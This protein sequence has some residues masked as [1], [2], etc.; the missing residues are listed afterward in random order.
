MFDNIGGKIK[1]LAVVMCILGMIVSFVMAVFLWTQ[2]SRDNSTVLAGFLTLGVGCLGSWIGSFFTYG[3]G[4]LIES[5]EEIAENTRRIA[6]MGGQ[7]GPVS[8]RPATP[9][10]STKRPSAKWHCAK[11][12]T[13]ND[14]TQIYC[15][16][17]GTYR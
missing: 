2:N 9:V 5:A 6:A 8:T 15:R 7:P 11:C 3:F 17:C 12:G 16:D 13:E 14:S 1:K 4:R 10:V